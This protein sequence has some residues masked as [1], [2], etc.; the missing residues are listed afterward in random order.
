MAWLKIYFD[1]KPVEAIPFVRAMAEVVGEGNEVVARLQGWSFLV[2]GNTPEAKLKLGA[3]GQ[4]DQIAALGLI[5][6]AEKDPAAKDASTPDAQRLMN[7]SPSRLTGALLYEAL[8]RVGIKPQPNPQRPRASPGLNN[9]P[10]T[11]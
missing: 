8:G 3:V 5:R 11:G 1:E 7:S 2:G 9:F 6:L 10:R 4:S